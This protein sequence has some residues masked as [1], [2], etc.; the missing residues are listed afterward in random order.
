MGLMCVSDRHDHLNRMAGINLET[1][2]PS[3][4]LAAEHRAGGRLRERFAEQSK[5]L[6]IAGWWNMRSVKEIHSVTMRPGVH[7]DNP[8]C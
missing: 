5:G 7:R 8:A 1:V 2:K 3:R 6:R 4:R